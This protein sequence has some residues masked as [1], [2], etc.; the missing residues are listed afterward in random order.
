[1][2]GIRGGV[3]GY[4][5]KHIVHSTIAGIDFE[6][7]SDVEIDSTTLSDAYTDFCGSAS[8]KPDWSIPVKLSIGGFRGLGKFERCFDAADMWSLFR[9]GDSRYVVHTGWGI[10]SPMWTAEFHTDIS[11]ITVHCG[12]VLLTGN[13]SG[14]SVSNPVRY[15]LDQILLTWVMGA[16]DRVRGVLV[17]CAG[18]ICD[19]RMW[20]LA[21]KSRAGK[22]TVSRLLK[23]FGGVEL[24]SDD[25]IVIR[26]P[27]GEFRGYGTPWPGE[28]KIAVNRSAPLAGILFL[29]QSPDNRISEISATEAFERMMPV[30]SVPWYEGTLFPAVMD[31]CGEVAQSLPVYRL[32]FRPDAAAADMIVKFMSGELR[33]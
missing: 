27:G 29:D 21:G 1:M 22:S 8:G 3:Q 16:E 13:G 23:G 10:E 26:K 12:D 2:V 5:M 6:I 18:M 4:G 20:L 14:G 31:F 17:H 30:T 19:G 28:A 32:E 33:K 9:E 11:S 25:R 15:P 24:I 7:E